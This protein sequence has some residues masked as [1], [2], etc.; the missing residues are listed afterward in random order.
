MTGPAGAPPSGARARRK[1][2]ATG[3][4]AGT[5]GRAGSRSRRK[6]RAGAPRAEG[7]A[8]VEV[9]NEIELE[10][11]LKIRP[12]IIGV[13]NRNLRTFEVDLE[14]TARLRPLVPADVILVADTGLSGIWTA[15]MIDFRSPGQTYLRAA[16]S[17]GWSFPA[18]LGAKCAAPDRPVVCF[19]GDG[20]FWY[21][22]AELETAVRLNIETV[23]LVNNNRSL[24][25]VIDPCK[26]AYGGKLRGKHAELWQ[27]ADV[28]FAELARTMGAEGIRVQKPGE[29]PGALGKAFSCR[30]PCVVEVLTEIT[31]MAP[32]AFLGNT[33]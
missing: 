31:A 9:H 26:E 3:Q 29:L 6:A 8:L 11:A 2:G 15:Q 16:G 33:P 24:N 1:P 32:L 27:F 10:Q 18:S 28:S 19:T 25:Q 21:H 13:N 20:G 22:L 7:A 30:R 17:L 12:R 4:P 14:T 23:L 5:K